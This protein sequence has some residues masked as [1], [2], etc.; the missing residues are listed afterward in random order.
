MMKKQA[1]KELRRSSN[2]NVAY[3]LYV[4]DREKKQDKSDQIKSC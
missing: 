4:S 3:S 1:F 2:A